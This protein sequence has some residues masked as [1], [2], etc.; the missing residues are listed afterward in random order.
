MSHFY[1]DFFF[2]KWNFGHILFIFHS[3]SYRIQILT[4]PH[5]ES[6]LPVVQYSI[7]S[8]TDSVQKTCIHRAKLTIM[9]VCDLG[10]WSILTG[11]HI[12]R[13]NFRENVSFLS[14][15]T[16]LFIINIWVSIER[17]CTVLFNWFKLR[18]HVT[19]WFFCS[20]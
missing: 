13:F 8:V 5:I 3:F 17:D 7:M 4:N 9:R 2:K 6:G 10:G 11:V 16:K 14:G 15:Q 18:I 1:C 12:R 20:V 19:T